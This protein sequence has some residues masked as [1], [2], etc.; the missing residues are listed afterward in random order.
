[1]GSFSFSREAFFSCFC[2]ET[3]RTNNENLLYLLLSKKNKKNKDPALCLCITLTVFYSAL[4]VCFYLLWHPF[5]SFCV[6]DVLLHLSPCCFYHLLAFAHPPPPNS[7]FYD[8]MLMARHYFLGIITFSAL[9]LSALFPL[10]SLS[11]PVI[12]PVYLVSNFNLLRRRILF[13]FFYW[14]R[15]IVVTPAA[16]GLFLYNAET[17]GGSY[18]LIVLLVRA[19]CYGFSLAFTDVIT[20]VHSCFH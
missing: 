16:T 3:P 13:L 17:Y 7:L 2:L 14:P 5:S 18:T 11:C 9:S 15:P 6:C 12:P 1:M 19:K 10:L 20:E 8:F 4:C